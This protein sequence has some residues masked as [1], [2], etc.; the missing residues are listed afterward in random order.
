MYT[1]HPTS[2]ETLLSLGFIPYDTSVPNSVADN[3]SS[4]CASSGLEEE[5]FKVEKV[6]GRRLSNDGLCYEYK[7]RFKGYGPEDDMWLPA[8]FLT[9][10]FNLSQ[11]PSLEGNENTQLIPKML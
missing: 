1:L 2:K 11:H 9:D 8:F 4:G 7:V 5:F 10:L 3:D 6:L